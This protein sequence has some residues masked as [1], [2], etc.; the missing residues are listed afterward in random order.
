MD[1]Y[2]YLFFLLL[3]VNFPPMLSHKDYDYKANKKWDKGCLV[4]QG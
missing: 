1:F 2:A 3:F 4:T